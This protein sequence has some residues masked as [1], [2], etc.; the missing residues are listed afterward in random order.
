MVLTGILL[1]EKQRGN[2]KHFTSIEYFFNLLEGF[3]KKCYFRTSSAN[4]LYLYLFWEID[5]KPYSK[6]DSS[7]TFFD[8]SSFSAFNITKKGH[9]RYLDGKTYSNRVIRKIYKE[10]SEEEFKF[11]KPIVLADNFLPETLEKK[12]FKFEVNNSV[13]IKLFLSEKLRTV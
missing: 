1:D 5:Y 12:F 11:L 4:S 10:L 3:Y 8:V 13:F 9:I 7:I 6:L 2:F